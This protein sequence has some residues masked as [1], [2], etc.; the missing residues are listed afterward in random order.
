MLDGDWGRLKQRAR[1]LE[2]LRQTDPVAK[3]LPPPVRQ[4]L[5]PH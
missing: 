1:D 5:P 4:V 3:R 2:R